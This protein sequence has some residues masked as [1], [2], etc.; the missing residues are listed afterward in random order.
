LVLGC[1]LITSIFDKLG[2]I[3]D[4]FVASIQLVL[5]PSIVDAD[6]KRFPTWHN[7]R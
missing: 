1:V 6:K 2:Y 4:I 3:V 5:T 7:D